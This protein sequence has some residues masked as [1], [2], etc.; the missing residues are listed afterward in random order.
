VQNV[1]SHYRFD[2]LY[3]PLFDMASETPRERIAR[4]Y[5][6]RLKKELLDMGINLIGGGISSLLPVQDELLTQRI[7]AW[8]ADWS[9][10]VVLKQAQSRTE[11]L[12]R[13][14]RAR[15]QAQAD[16]ILAL[17]ERLASLGQPDALVS[18][19]R[20]LPQFLRILEEVA[21]QPA[22]QRYLPRDT[23]QDVRRLRETIGE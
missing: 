9:R 18:P 7:R 16:L 14:E 17:G 21:A 6:E 5:R 23:G 4:E 15:A 1:L 20:I 11:W 2:E 3:G 8:Q 22:L 13:V 10:R 19:E 12:Q